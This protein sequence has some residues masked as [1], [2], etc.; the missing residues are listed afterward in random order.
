[1]IFFVI[2]DSNSEELAANYTFDPAF[3]NIGNDKKVNVPDLS[4]FSR[5]D[6]VLPGEYPVDV[7]VNNE[8]FGTETI[9]FVSLGKGKVVPRLT[10]TS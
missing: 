5:A 7:N 3:I 9:L 6:G 8:S 2:H 4:Y 1:L 10:E